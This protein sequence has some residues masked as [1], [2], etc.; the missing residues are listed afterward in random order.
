MVDVVPAQLRRAAAAMDTVI[1][2]VKGA[3][4]CDR[5]PDVAVGLPGGASASQVGPLVPE[6]DKRFKDWCE[7]AT[8]QSDGYRGAARGYEEADLQA[9]SEGRGQTTVL[10]SQGGVW[11]RDHGLG[12]GYE[13][14]PGIFRPNDPSTGTTARIS[15]RLGGDD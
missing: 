15:E 10:S 1:E 12:S 11:G 9:E 7:G 3:N 8:Q 6:F 13:R 4:P 5:M 2:Q 14:G